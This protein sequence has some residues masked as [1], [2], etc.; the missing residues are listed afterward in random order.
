MSKG[1][2]LNDGL[3]VVTAYF[4]IGSFAKGS[5]DIKY[6]PTLYMNWLQVFGLIESRVIGFFDTDE[7]LDKFIKLRQRFPSNLTVAH[8]LN[9]SQV[10]QMDYS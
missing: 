3:T 5:P 2:K 1:S 9:R 4:D 7:H 6:T 10:R 8:K